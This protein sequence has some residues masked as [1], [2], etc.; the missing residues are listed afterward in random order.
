MSTKYLIGVDGGSQSSKVT[1]FDLAGNVICEGRQELRP[2]YM[3][4]PGVVEQELGL[5]LVQ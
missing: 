4:E 5:E 3:P 2:L 1:I